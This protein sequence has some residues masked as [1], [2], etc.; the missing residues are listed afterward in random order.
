MEGLKTVCG[1]WV[2]EK[3]RWMFHVD[4]KRGTKV[5][6]VN[7][8]TSFEDLINKVHED[9]RL[10]KGQVN[11]E[12]SYMFS[13]KSLKNLNLDTPP[14]KIENI[15]Q[16][17]GFF[18]GLKFERVRLCVEVTYKGS[19][20]TMKQ[21]THG[22]HVDQSD[23]DSDTDGE[24]FDYCDDSDGATS[25]D[26]DFIAYG[27]PLEVD[28]EMKKEYKPQIGSATKS[29]KAGVVIPHV[30][31]Q[32]NSINIVVGQSFDSKSALKTRL[33]I[34]TIVQQF[35]YDVEYSTPT[36]L[37]VKCW[38]RGCSWKLRASPT[39]NTPRFTVRTFVSDHTCSVTERSARCRQATPEILGS[40]YTDFIGGVEPTI[41][42]SHVK[43]SLNMCFGIKINYWKAH[44][45]LKCAREL[46]RG[47][48]ESGYHELPV[49]LHKIREA[50]PGTFT[51]LVVDSSDRFKYLFIAF[52][53]SI[54]GFPF[55]RKVVV[56]DGTFLQGKYKGTLLIASSQD[57]N[58]QIFPIAFAI[59]DTE[60]DESW[61]WF[62]RQ[63][64]CVIP[65]DERLA[66]ISDRHKSIGNAI[67]EVYPSASRGVCTY[68]LYK[69][70]LLK[71]RGR[72]L[73]GLVKKAAN[74]FRLSDFETTF[75]EIKALHPALHGYLQKA[76]VRKWAR[77]H[78]PGDRYNLTTTNIAESI[79]R[80][81]SGARTLPIVRLLEAIRQMMTRWFSARKND[82]YLMKT[83]LT[84]GVEKLLE[85]HLSFYN[86]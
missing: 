33:K 24:R 54:K 59:V 13:K 75:D 43:K 30:R 42:P 15:C 23:E 57:G 74:S 17:Q 28:T 5:I 32:L 31:Q 29:K 22:E 47:S 25:D 50:N 48:A 9:Y 27:L 36:L 70:V 73:F 38:I 62:F 69:N 51:R 83:T 2:F 49:Y 39:S 58:F 40:L 77:A 63:L 19:E 60:N 4:N 3:E 68:H 64:S 10:D 67:S 1:Q 84:R 44:R 79:N 20:E 80:V 53:A 55:M 7:D 18:R 16:L 76:D 65:D 82:A 71:F 56:V 34:L 6:P 86:T 21:S 35:D 26:E 61:K 46:V 78:F 11:V 41:L 81:L 37:I 72:E 66:I 45:T 52:G 14:V 8:N 12:L 85:V